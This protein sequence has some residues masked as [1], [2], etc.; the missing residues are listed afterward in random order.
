[1]SADW[2]TNVIVV[3]VDGSEQSKHAARVAAAM[4][5]DLSA[6]LHLVTVVRPPEGWWGIVGSPPTPGAFTRALSEAQ[7]TVLDSI[8]SSLDLAGIEYQTVEDI[9]DPG[10]TLID[11]C[12][13]EKADL[14]VVGR[15]GVG[16]LER[17]VMGSVANRVVQE[18]P[19]PV[20][21]VP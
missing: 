16:L 3:G 12:E 21:V 13:R 1:M 14:L 15:R 20:L 10:K 2:Q 5:R 18:A 7:Q 6:K 8:T 4:A 11:Y 9:G 17:I 19:C